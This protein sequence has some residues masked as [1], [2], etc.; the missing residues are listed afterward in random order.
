MEEFSLKNNQ[1]FTLWPAGWICVYQ[2]MRVIPGYLESW[3]MTQTYTSAHFHCLTHL[4]STTE[5]VCLLS[6]LAS[7]TSILARYVGRQSNLLYPHQSSNILLFNELMNEWLCDFCQDGGLAG[8]IYLNPV[9]QHPLTQ[10]STW[11]ESPISFLNSPSE[12]NFRIPRPMILLLQTEFSISMS[13]QPGKE[14]VTFY[15]TLVNKVL[16]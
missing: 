4:G 8:Q 6:L 7:G 12:A 5:L 15:T 1:K 10:M 11:G 13:Q 14:M 9:R 16:K 2:G 3:Q